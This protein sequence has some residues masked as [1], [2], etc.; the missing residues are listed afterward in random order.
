MPAHPDAAGDQITGGSPLASGFG[1]PCGISVAANP[2]ATLRGR[3]NTQRPS[4]AASAEPLNS[5]A[6]SVSRAIFSLLTAMS[7]TMQSP[8]SAPPS[9]VLS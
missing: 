5:W 7:T 2:D 3:T 1:Q 6:S 9:D 4:T 8:G